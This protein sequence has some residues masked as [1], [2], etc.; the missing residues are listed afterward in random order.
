MK[1]QSVRR[2]MSAFFDSELDEATTFEINEHLHVCAACR[3]RFELERRV[4]LDILE[5]LRGESMPD[6][7][8]DAIRTT[9]ER[10]TRAKPVP[11]RRPALL[12]TMAVATA[13]AILVGVLHLRPDS[14]WLRTEQQVE[15]FLTL[16]SHMDADTWNGPTVSDG[17]PV[18]LSKSVILRLGAEASGHSTQLVSVHD[19]NGPEGAFTEV[20][21]A[22]CG[23]PVLLRIARSDSRG[24]LGALAAQLAA[25]ES[26]TRKYNRLAVAVRRTGDYVVV[27]VSRHPIAHLVEA[28]TVA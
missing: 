3:E 19:R 14:A 24:E 26:A 16:T 11:V 28:V 9:V 13:A 27:A 6:A 23:E 2:R 22:C 4:D 12:W 17:A 1:C 7:T 10:S 5:R 8:W 20:L 18:R 25:D 15:A 21:L